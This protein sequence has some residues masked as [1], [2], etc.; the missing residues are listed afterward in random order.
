MPKARISLETNNRVY[1]LTPTIR[2]WYYIFDRHERWQILSDSLTY[3]Q[4]E[5][6][7]EIFAYVFMLN[8]LHLIASCG[9]MAGFVR[10]FKRHTSRELIRNIKRTEPRVLALFENEDGSLS[11]WQEG[12][13]PKLLETE[14]FFMQK[15]NYIHENPVRKGY[16]ERAEH[17]KWSSANPKSP[18]KVAGL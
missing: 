6:G 3:C 17:W 8:H 14:H 1:F 2:N 10:D 4:R 7:L 13:Q 11:F 15:M 16:V 5:K 18:I 12:N 9:D